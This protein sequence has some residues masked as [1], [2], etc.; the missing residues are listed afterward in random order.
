[1]RKRHQARLHGVGQG[2][3]TTGDGRGVKIR[4]AVQISVLGEC[5]EVQNPDMWVLFGWSDC[6]S[7]NL[8]KRCFCKVASK[9]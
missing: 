6:V 4:R 8:E 9:T 3:T 7:Q 1:M 5:S 2:S